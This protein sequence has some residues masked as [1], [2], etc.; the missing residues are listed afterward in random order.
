MMKKNMQ[1]IVNQRRL[2]SVSLSRHLE[3]IV[4]ILII[5]I[6]FYLAIKN[7][8]CALDK[9][10]IPEVSAAF[11][12]FKVD[13]AIH[14]SLYGEWPTDSDELAGD[15]SDEKIRLYQKEEFQELLGTYIKRGSFGEYKPPDPNKNSF[16]RYSNIPLATVTHDL[17]YIL[18]DGSVTFN[19]R[20]YSF[21]V[22]HTNPLKM[23][24]FRPIT[25][26]GPVQPTIA[27]V[28]GNSKIPENMQVYGKNFTNIDNRLLFESC[29]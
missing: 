9:V 20:G 5:F 8:Q 7:Y 19:L 18:Q 23:I 28:C 13:L 4:T 25:L 24:S 26:K 3:F 12:A 10:K 6:L 22:K 1:Q 21:V 14:Y 27:W 15:Y 11:S 2:T 17:D 29:R 16:Y